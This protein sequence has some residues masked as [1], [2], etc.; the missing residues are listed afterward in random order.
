MNPADATETNAAAG[1]SRLG[2]E[3]LTNST[4][5]DDVNTM[6]PSVGDGVYQQLDVE[7]GGVL[8]EVELAID[9][10]VTPEL[11]ELGSSGCYFVK[12]RKQVS[13]NTS[14]HSCVF[15]HRVI[16]YIIARGILF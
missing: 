14:I 11:S 1:Q 6:L 2:Y 3:E 9:E 15:I 13:D 16:C 7:F 5:V 4:S 10:G 12:E 8:R